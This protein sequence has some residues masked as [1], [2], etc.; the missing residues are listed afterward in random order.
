MTKASVT[1]AACATVLWTEAALAIPT[2][3]QKCEAGKNL[4]AGKYAACL[5]TAQ[6]NLVL[7]GDTIKYNTAV[8]RC[9]A[10]LAKT[11]TTLEA[12]AIK[13]GTTCPSTGDETAMQTFLTANADTV[14]GALHTPPLIT[15]VATCNAYLATCNAG[16]AVAGNVLSGRTFSSS[17]GLGVTGTMPNNG[18]V[19]LTPGTADQAIG[20]GYHNG[21]GKCAGDAN[22]TTANIKSGA[23]IFGVSGGVIQ[24]SGNAAGG[25]VLSG[26]TFSNANGASTGTMPNNGAVMLTPSTT[27]QAIVAGYHNGSGYCAGD[28]NLVTGNITSG[29]SIFGVTGTAGVVPAQPLRTGLTQCA[30][31]ATGTGAFGACPATVV[32]QDGDFQKGTARSYTDNGD[33]TITDNRTGLMWEKLD[34][35]N[36][37]GIHDKDNTYTWSTAFTTKMATLNSTNFA[38]HNDWRLPNRFEL[39]TLVDPGRYNPSIDPAFN[40]G[41]AASCTVTTCSCTYP[42]NTWSSST[43]VNNTTYA[44][45]VEFAGGAVVADD[46][47]SPGIFARAVRG[48]L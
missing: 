17:A 18:A 44:W 9:D 1:V 46:K 3:Q 47:P 23:S 36:A 29:A 35:N 43:N 24:A 21:S 32:G 31:G 40:T 14:G 39:E 41:C 33:G 19:M 20:A 26:Q 16:T 15:D 25:D 10:T 11:W 38:G 27:D 22:L 48:G 28:A 37:G 6:K 5:Q 34:D 2:A 7:N 45:V 12:A 4:A 13:K 42:F 30:T 8:G